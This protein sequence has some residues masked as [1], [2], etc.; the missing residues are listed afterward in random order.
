MSKKNLFVSELYGILDLLVKTTKMRFSVFLTSKN[1]RQLFHK[2][3]HIFDY[4]TYTIFNFFN[5]LTFI[6][7]SCVVLFQIDFRIVF[8]ISRD[9][10]EI[11]KMGRILREK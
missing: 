9:S 5:D 3:S 11:E 10:C 8:M 6:N 2:K 7:F 1:S 4:H